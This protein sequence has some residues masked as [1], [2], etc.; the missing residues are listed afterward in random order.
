MNTAKRLPPDGLGLEFL[1]FGLEFT[2]QHL[3]ASGRHLTENTHGM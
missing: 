1:G 2:L 3:L